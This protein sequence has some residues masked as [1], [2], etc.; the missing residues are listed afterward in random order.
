[1]RANVEPL[2]RQLADIWGRFPEVELALVFGS[3]ARG[4]ATL[5]SDLDI[6]VV[7]KNVDVLEL[8]RVVGSLVAREVQVSVLD[9]PSIVLLNEV[10]SEGLPLFETED[11]VYARWVSRTLLQLEDDLPWYRRQRNAWL[12][13]VGEK[14]L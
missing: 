14:G 9:D 4:Q 2:R 6:A 1:M 10:V 8:S 12:R 7:G 13:R 5:N 11:G 3:V